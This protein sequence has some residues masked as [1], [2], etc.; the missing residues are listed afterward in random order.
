MKLEHE[1]LTEKIIAAAIEVHKTLGPGFLESVYENALSIECESCDIPYEKQWEIPLFYKN[2]E[3]GKHRLDMFVFNEIVVE[4]KAIK[5]VSNEHFAIV[6][7]YLK[8]VGQKHGLILNFS[9]PTLEIKR[10]IL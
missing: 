6:R 7:S 2:V 10:V 9:K 1:E 3:I 4:L 5:D 8:A